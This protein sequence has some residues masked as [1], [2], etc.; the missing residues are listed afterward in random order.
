MEYKNQSLTKYLFDLSAKVDAPGGGS[1]AALNAAMGAS[2]VSMVINFTLGKTRY[3]KYEAGLKEILRKSDKLKDDFLSLVDLDVLAYKSKDPR[4][5]MDVPLMLARL[6][7][8]GM[9]LLAPLI[10]KTNVNLISD[11]AISAIFLES[12]FSSA[13][14]NVDI[15]L[16][17][18]SDKKLTGAIN[19]ELRLKAIAVKQMRAKLEEKVGKIIR[20]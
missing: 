3:S 11:L 20:G 17:M 4:K 2:L 15:N 10:R 7:Y 6:C 9:K 8:E 18:L 5:A 1:A 14:L 13:Y 19:K 16:K 12:A